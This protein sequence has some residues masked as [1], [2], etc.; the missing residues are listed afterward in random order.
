MKLVEKKICSCSRD[1]RIKNLES[2]VF[3]LRK[4]N[5]AIRRP[6]KNMK[7]LR[8]MDHQMVYT[9]MLTISRFL[10]NYPKIWDQIQCQESLRGL[11]I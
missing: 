6:G 2:P 1:L 7:V 10:G 5:R 3:A 4:D 8:R 11:V 9:D